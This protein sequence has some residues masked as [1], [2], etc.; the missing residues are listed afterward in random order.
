MYMYAEDTHRVIDGE[1]PC[2]ARGK[3]GRASKQGNLSTL[4]FD[5]SNLIN[6]FLQFT[7]V[8]LR[9]MYP[10]SMYIHDTTEYNSVVVLRRALPTSYDIPY[11]S[12]NYHFVSC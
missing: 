8:Y 5:S 9:R 7:C 12:Y 3:K 2:H 6:G 10:V 1:L 11:Y 4:G